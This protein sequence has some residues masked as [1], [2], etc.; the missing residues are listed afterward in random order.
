M[1]LAVMPT[2]PDVG[3]GESTEEQPPRGTAMERGPRELA[4]REAG[5]QAVAWGRWLLDHQREWFG[6]TAPPAVPA[7]DDA[8]VTAAAT[9]Y[10]RRRNAQQRKGDKPPAA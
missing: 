2:P 10:A 9:D 5:R 3:P 1:P 8:A 6:H 4:A 7:F